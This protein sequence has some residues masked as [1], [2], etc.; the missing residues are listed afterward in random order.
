[1]PTSEIMKIKTKR[2]NLYLRVSKGHFATSNSHSNYYIDVA[3]QKSRLSE[4]QAVAEELCSYYRHNTIVDTILCLDGMEVVGTCLADK[5]TQG[6]FVNL[7]AHQTIYVVTPEST[8]ASQ[9][10]FRDNIVPMIAGKHVLILAV[11]V[12]SG[13]TVEA[14]I[15]AVNYYGGNVVGVSSIFA[16]KQ[17]CGGY[18]V[19]SVFDPSDLPGYECYSPKDCPMCKRGEKIDA[20][21]NYHGYSKL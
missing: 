15:D 21:V 19:H 8:N 18:P 5:L 14:A 6:D 13:R 10:L 2:E 17:E 7:N 11:S 1:M 20:L 16:S 4:A 12:S 3:A 9:L